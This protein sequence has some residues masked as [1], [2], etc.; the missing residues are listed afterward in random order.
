MLDIIT[1]II[2][3]IVSQMLAAI[4]WKKITDDQ[5]DN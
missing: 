3:D 4:G 5:T 2:T 1:D